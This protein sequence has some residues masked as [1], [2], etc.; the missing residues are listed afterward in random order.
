MVSGE[1][2]NNEELHS[3]YLSP[4]IVR[5]IKSRRL[6]WAGQVAR[7]EED[8]NALKMLIG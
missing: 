7:I 6:R 4:N 5:L 3:L 1:G 8:R 2:S